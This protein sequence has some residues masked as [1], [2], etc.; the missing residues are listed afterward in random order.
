MQPTSSVLVHC[1][2]IELQGA[3]RGKMLSRLAFRN[4]ELE[5]SSWQISI[6]L[7]KVRVSVRDFL[8]ICR[9]CHCQIH[10]DYFTAIM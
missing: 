5:F 4:G 3:P 7:S 10:V 9:N 6:T 2:K 8:T 1:S